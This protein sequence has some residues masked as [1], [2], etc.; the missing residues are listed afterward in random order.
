MKKGR[1]FEQVFK[2]FPW[3]E[4][5]RGSNQ[6]IKTKHLRII[7]G[8][9]FLLPSIFDEVQH[10]DDLAFQVLKYIL[11]SFRKKHYHIKS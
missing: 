8:S 2:K 3:D 6:I 11:E 5:R 4:S 7:V 1:K 9:H 10:L